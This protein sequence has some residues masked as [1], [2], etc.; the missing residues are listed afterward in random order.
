MDNIRTNRFTFND[1]YISLLTPEL[2]LAHSPGIRATM[3]SQSSWIL[4]PRLEYLLSSSARHQSSAG[5]E[6]IFPSVAIATMT[7]ETHIH[8]NNHLSGSQHEQGTNHVAEKGIYCPGPIDLSRP[9]PLRLSMS[10][11]QVDKGGGYFPNTPSPLLPSLSAQIDAA[12]CQVSS[13]SSKAV[14]SLPMQVSSITTTRNSL[15]FANGEMPGLANPWPPTSGRNASTKNFLNKSLLG[16]SELAQHTNV[17]G[18]QD[19]RSMQ[20]ADSKGLKEKTA[21]SHNN[22]TEI[23]QT[24]NELGGIDRAPISK[25]N[26]SLTFMAGSTSR[27]STYSQACS[28]MALR[29]VGNVYQLE[30]W[31]TVDPLTLNKNSDDVHRSDDKRIA[32]RSTQSK[33]TYLP[34]DDHPGDLQW[35]GDCSLSHPSPASC[36]RYPHDDKYPAC[37]PSVMSSVSKKEL[38]CLSDNIW[39]NTVAQRKSKEGILRTYLPFKIQHELLGNIQTLIEETCFYF[40]QKWLPELLKRQGWSTPEQGE[41]TSWWALLQDCHV[42]RQA[43]AFSDIKASVVFKNCRQ[44]RNCAVHREPV[45]VSGIKSMIRDAI[46]LTGGF[47]DVIREG[48]LRKFQ[49]CL[50]R[51]DL[52]AL[53]RIIDEPLANFK[54]FQDAEVPSSKGWQDRDITEVS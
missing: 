11:A 3:Q 24:D 27:S 26:T 34:H 1:D 29:G 50:D 38:M 35:S 15:G 16:A 14:C 8:M 39:W 20:A 18:G 4:P 23:A 9:K 2:G 51:R 28:Q 48:K 32:F 40:A 43:I 21:N 44:I 53:Q 25:V 12:S 36:T 41:L 52:D 37:E 31:T 47:K 19:V 7:S 13:S 22:R 54:A 33:D 6:E 49:D 42:P 17:F 10:S 46:N 30:S 5:K 45:P